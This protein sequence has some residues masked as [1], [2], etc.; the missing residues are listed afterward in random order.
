MGVTITKQARYLEIV[1]I[2]M[3]F[4]RGDGSGYSCY[5]T[6]DGEP[7]GWTVYEA[8]EDI[9]GDFRVSVSEPFGAA[10][11]IAKAL[12]NPSLEVSVEVYQG[13]D[14][15]GAEGRCVCGGTVYLDDIYDNECS[16]RCGRTY[17]QQGW[18]MAPVWQR[19]EEIAYGMEEEALETERLEAS[20]ER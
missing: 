4:D 7:V 20:Y 18:E 10:G 17:A 9:P 19:G 8:D 5:L 6:V 2:S 12:D 13:R 3:H 14:R 1:R 11:N 16:K 15:I